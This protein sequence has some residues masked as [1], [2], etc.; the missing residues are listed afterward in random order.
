MRHWLDV[1]FADKDLAKRCGANWDPAVKR[2][3]APRPGMVGLAKW[4]PL[5]ELLPGEDRTFGS[6]LLVDPIPSTTWFNNARTCIAGGDWQRVRMLVLRRAGH[7]CE[8]CGRPEDK[9]AGRRLECHERWAYEAAAQRQVLRRLV[10]FCSDCHTVTHFGLA[11]IRGVDAAAFAHLCEV[12]G[13]SEAEANRHLRA[14]FALWEQRSGIAWELDLGILT[15]A[16]IGFARPADRGSRAA[17]SA[18]QGRIAT[19]PPPTRQPPV[20]IA[21]RQRQPGTGSRWDQWL[22]TGER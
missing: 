17:Q 9:G 11:Q 12:T 14:A 7:R 8:A 10:C 3:Y 20:T 2:W 6:G 16:G 4:E 15:L 1:P 19:A 18:D 22:Q 13:M 5:P 21:A